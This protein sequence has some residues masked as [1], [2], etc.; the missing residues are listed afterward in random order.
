[1]SRDQQV[2]VTAHIV[3]GVGGQTGRPEI[4]ESETL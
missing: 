1:M 2:L 4:G 3:T